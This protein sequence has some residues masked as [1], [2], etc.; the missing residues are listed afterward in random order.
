M[1]NRGLPLL[2]HVKNPCR[3]NRDGEKTNMVTRTE[4]PCAFCEGV[5]YVAEGQNAYTHGRCRTE[6][7]DLNVAK[8]KGGIKVPITTDLSKGEGLAKPEEVK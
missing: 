4:K 2:S 6:Y 5:M 8:R 7:R 1:F 3:L